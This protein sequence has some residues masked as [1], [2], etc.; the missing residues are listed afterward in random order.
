VTRR[1]VRLLGVAM[2]F[3]STM[4]ASLAPLLPGY[5][6]DLAIST[7]DAGILTGL[8]GCGLV[9]ASLPAGLLAA[10][11]GARPTVV[12]GFVVMAAASAAF[13]FADTLASLDIARFAQ[14]VASGLIWSGA[15]TWAAASTVEAELGSTI[16]QLMGIAIAGTLLGPPLGAL[17]VA[18]SQQLVFSLFAAGA[19][20]MSVMLARRPGGAPVPGSPRPPASAGHRGRLVAAAWLLL[21]PSIAYGLVIVLGALRLDAVG[22]TGVGVAAVFLVGGIAE[23]TASPVAGGLTDRH[24]AARIVR[25]ALVIV[26]VVL[27]ALP[28]PGAPLLVALSLVVALGALG[29][30]WVPASVLVQG[31][32]V[33]S[34]AAGAT[35][36]GAVTVCFAA[37]QM[38]GA[39]VGT[40]L[41]E[42]GGMQLPFV[43]IAIA[44][45]VTAFAHRRKTVDTLSSQ[46]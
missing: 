30:F 19:L 23:A 9:L 13:A 15:L 5:V 27:L 45:V 25:A 24:G 35:A 2:I 37:G 20:G 4:F 1:T 42:A 26:A 16:G 14:G 7:V 6:H 8:F 31:A 21:L 18:T 33:A 22:V 39:P 29:L 17:A 38:L 3:E 46:V 11:I 43:L 10:R 36:W 12:L 32:V 44:F 40:V 34:G 41:A 28:L